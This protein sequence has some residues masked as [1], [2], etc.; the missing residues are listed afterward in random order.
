MRMVK[1]TR[2]DINM[3]YLLIFIKSEEG[4]HAR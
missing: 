2:M 3:D 1:L 4:Y